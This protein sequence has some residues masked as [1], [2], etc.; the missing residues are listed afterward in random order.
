[1]EYFS[2][3]FEPESLPARPARQPLWLGKNN[4]GRVVMLCRCARIT[5]RGLTAV[6][7][8]AVLL[9]LPPALLASECPTVAD[10]KG[11]KAAWPEQ[12]ELSAYQQQLGKNLVF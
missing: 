6:S 4:T 7:A 8:L 10:S 3:A 1:M 11:I 9:S 12:L 5:I 2:A